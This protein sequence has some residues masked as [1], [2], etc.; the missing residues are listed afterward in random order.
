VPNFIHR[1]ASHAWAA[2]SSG[3]AGVGANHPITM[4]HLI[5]LIIGLLLLS[6]A[7]KAGWFSQDP[8]PLAQA[9]EKIVVLENTVA[10]QTST[11]NRWQIATGS[12]A[13]CCVILLIIGAALGAK[14]RHY[15]HESTRRLG[16]TSPPPSPSALNGR[17]SA[18]VDEAAEEH[19]HSTLAA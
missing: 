13:V 5:L 6:S 17:K 16:R 18:F 9:Q 3:S 11:M 10:T 1:P 12:L 14:T 15:H 8:D 2:S 7:A 4:K 19:T